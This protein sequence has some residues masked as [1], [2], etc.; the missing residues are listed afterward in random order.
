MAKWSNEYPGQSG[1]IHLS[2]Q[3]R[4]GNALFHDAQAD[5]T[6]SRLQRQF[7][8]GQLAYMPELCAM[9]AQTVNAYSRMVPGFWAPTV[10]TWGVD[11]RTT[12]LRVIPGGASAQRVEMRL[13]AADANPYLALAAAVQPFWS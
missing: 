3:D 10:A 11:N 12:A 1:H 6:M 5:Y 13:T 8:A 4:Q 2:L 9:Y 7:V